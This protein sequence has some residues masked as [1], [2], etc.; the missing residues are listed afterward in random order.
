M[1]KLIAVSIKSLNGLGSYLDPRFGRSYGFLI[2][3]IETGE[4]VAQFFNNAASAAHGAGTAA[5]HWMKINDVNGVI[6]GRFGPKA[7]QALE[8]LGIEMWI[9][10]EGITAAEAV[11]LY[12]AGELERATV[13]VY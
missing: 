5:S 9:A 10:P 11:A 4:I 3:E 13:K 8:A 12:R 1:T 7:V 6:S 2:V